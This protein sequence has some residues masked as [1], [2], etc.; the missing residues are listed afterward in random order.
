MEFNL[1]GIGVPILPYSIGSCQWNRRN[2]Y[3][4]THIRTCQ[5][6]FAWM[7]GPVDLSDSPIY[8]SFSKIQFWIV[9]AS[10]P[11]VIWECNQDPWQ[12]WYFT[13]SG[14]KLVKTRVRFSLLI[15]HMPIH[16]K[17]YFRSM[18][19]GAEF[20][21]KKEKHSS[22]DIYLRWWCE[23]RL[24]HEERIQTRARNLNFN[25]LTFMFLRLSSRCF[26]GF[27]CIV[28]VPICRCEECEM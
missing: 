18:H 26:R 5:W 27:H 19:W 25:F 21:F 14:I 2:S 17:T 28:V 13:N 4:Q 1:L 10:R 9:D 20:F 6:N 15:I 11:V 22:A 23:S 12:Q 16:L 8:A 24:D 3:F 7:L